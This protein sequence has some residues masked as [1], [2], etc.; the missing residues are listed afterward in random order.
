MTTK[1]ASC[2]RIIINQENLDSRT[3][4]NGPSHE[5]SHTRDNTLHH[6]NASNYRVMKKSNK[7]CST[8][9]TLVYSHAQSCFWSSWERWD[10]KKNASSFMS[11][12]LWCGSESTSIVDAC[13][14]PFFLVGQFLAM[15]PYLSHLKHWILE[16]LFYVHDLK[17][18]KFSCLWMLC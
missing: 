4:N 1:M 7:E 16:C 6:Q 3:R 15:C 10:M 12:S 13:C 14:L 18:M 2:T 11:S 8:K 5:G 9:L 17:L